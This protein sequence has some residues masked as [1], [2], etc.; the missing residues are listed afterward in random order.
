VLVRFRNELNESTSVHWHG[1]HLPANMDGGP[2]QPVGPGQEWQPYWSIKQ[3]AATL[4]YHPHPHG[5]TEQQVYRGLAGM[6]IIDDEISDRLSLPSDYGVNDIPVIVQDKVFN[7]AGELRQGERAEVGL[8]GDTILVN[9]AYAPYFTVTTT[10]VRL[11]L[12]NGSTARIYNFGFAD[13]REF[14]LIATDGGLLSAPHR[15]RRIQLS[16]GERA[17]IVVALEPNTAATLHAYPPDLGA[18]LALAGAYGSQDE[19]DILRLQAAAQ[20][21]PLPDLP[22]SLAVIER[23]HESDAV[24]T[25]TFRL[26]GRQINDRRMDMHRIDEVVTVGNTEIWDVFNQNLYPHNFHIHD[27][28]C[29]ILD[30]DGQQ[31]PPELAGWKDTVYLRPR[32]HYR[33]IMR[34]ADYTDVTTP[35][36]YHCHLLWHEDNGM[37]GQFVVV[38]PGEE[39]SVGWVGG[40]HEFGHPN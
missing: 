33:L 10:Q 8:L 25:R 2:H 27:V 37:M 23:L 19:F 9:G 4:W 20:L 1:M 21:Q 30:I 22:A 13:D 14:H 11:R 26:D 3:P 7:R 12:L 35:Y 18:V 5:E 40:S 6:F 15:T 17:E 32:T 28:Q 36:M 38:Q 16:P 29:Q 34:F 31:P 39:G 24:Q